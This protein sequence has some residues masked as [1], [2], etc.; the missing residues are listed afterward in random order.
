MWV[1]ICCIV[2]ILCFCLLFFW[3]CCCCVC[4]WMCGRWGVW[5]SIKCSLG[6][7]MSCLRCG[8]V[9]GL[10]CGFFLW[11]L[12]FCKFVCFLW[13]NLLV[14]DLVC[15]CCLWWRC[16]CSLCFILWLKIMVIIGCIDGCIMVGGMIMYIVCIMSFWFWWVLLCFMCIGWR[17]WF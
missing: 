12:G 4:C 14:F 11:W 10:W 16:V 6:C 13:W 8:G 5:R 7:I 9:I 17:L 15:C 1:I 2:W 3:F